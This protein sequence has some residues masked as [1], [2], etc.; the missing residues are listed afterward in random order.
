MVNR[1]IIDSESYVLGSPADDSVE[2]FHCDHNDDMKF[3]PRHIGERFPSLTEIWILRCGLTVLRNHYFENMEN[4]EKMYLDSNQIAL[5]EPEAFKD[6]T[7]LTRLDLHNNVIETLPE[8]LFKTMTSLDAIL[9][10]SNR[11]NF[12]SPTMFKLPG[13]RLQT[14]QLGWNVCI[15]ENYYADNYESTSFKQLK[16]DLRTNCTGK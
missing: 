7:G 2:R 13:G 15:H 9:L 4:L 6:L 10:N 16:S 14:V 5:I 11:I 12:L 8:K 1:Q 3:L